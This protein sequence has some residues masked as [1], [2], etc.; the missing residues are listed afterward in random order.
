[1][2][3]TELFTIVADTMGGGHDTIGGCCSAASNLF[4]YKVPDTPGCHADFLRALARHGMGEKD[5]VAK[6]QLL[7][8]R[9]GAGG[10]DHGH[11]RR[12]VEAG[13]LR[14]VAGRVARPGDFKAWVDEEAAMTVREQETLLQA[15]ELWRKAVGEMTWEVRAES[16]L[17]MLLVRDQ[18]IEDLQRKIRDGDIQ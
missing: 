17:A 18:E 1:V 4:R 8:E 13:R 10:R 5:I 12:P 16:A 9:P 15:L 11:R 14:R 2:R 6:H 3:A 7:H